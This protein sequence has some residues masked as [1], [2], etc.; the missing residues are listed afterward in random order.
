MNNRSFEPAAGVLG[1]AK[2]RRLGDALRLAEQVLE[3]DPAEAARR[4]RALLRAFPKLAP[5]T[6]ILGAARRRQGSAAEARSLLAPLARAHP[7]DALIQYELAEALNDLGR[8]DAAR[9]A[10][11]LAVTARPAFGKAW[12]GLAERLHAAGD[13]A[14]ADDAFGRYVAC[15]VEDAPLV[16]SLRA[17]Q[18]GD[19]E[20]AQRMLGRQLEIV[21]GDVVAMVLLADA[22]MRKGRLE[23]ADRLLADCLRRHPGYAAAQAVRANLRVRMFQSEQAIIQDSERAAAADPDNAQACLLLVT[24]LLAVGEP[25]RALEVLEARLSVAATDPRLWVA[26]GELLKAVGRGPEA[27]AA[28]RQAIAV[29]PGHAEGW[30]HLADLKSYAFTPEDVAAMEARLADDGT[31]EEARVHLRHA[32]ARARED[33]GDLPG[34]FADYAAA[35]AL[36]RGRVSHSPEA[37]T[38][39]IHRK[40][41][42]FTPT[43]FAARE[44][45][46]SQ[47]RSPIFVV[48]MQRSGSTLV[49]QILG[50]HSA[51]EAVGELPYIR[52]IANRIVNLPSSPGRQPYP[53]RLGELSPEDRLDF[54]ETYLERAAQRRKLKRPRF[55]DKMP[56]N[57]EHVGLIHLLLPRA[58]IID[59]RRHPLACGLG[60]FRQHFGDAGGFSN[61]LGDIG[62]A[63]RDYVALMAQ[64]DRALPG[65]VCRVIY[66][67][68]V[69]DTETEVRR[70]LDYCGL[71]FEEGCLRYYETRRVVTT[72]SAEQVRRP[73]Y[74]DGLDLWRAYEPWLE[75]LKVA[76]GPTLETWRSPPGDLPD[77]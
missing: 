50:S 5:A 22:L 13:G 39:R 33:V 51:V 36:Q 6:A 2:D 54:A 4:A 16:E 25:E 3:S 28:F 24:N 53:E 9:E 8:F 43:F 64:I 62:L 31:D 68:L 10:F 75:P 48:G 60:L 55:L 46:G 15:P 73:I 77:D 34:A 67:D 23:S 11:R 20:T 70:V 52:E 49:E 1:V 27:I 57:F 72:P 47:E 59:V 42:L 17:L 56:G 37:L 63:Y 76:L 69:E 74:R 30:R 29:S 61:D 38:D 41:S 35:A 26:R 21:P 44:G 71:A 19:L 12:R 65:R 7:A 14:A 18:R 45:G 66:E 32:L 58:G 40:V